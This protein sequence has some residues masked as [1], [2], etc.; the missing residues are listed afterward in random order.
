MSYLPLQGDVY[1]WT[2]DACTDCLV[3]LAN[4]D[5]PDDSHCR[6]LA[7]VASVRDYSPG[8]HE[9]GRECDSHGFSWSPCDLCGCHLGGDRYPVTYLPPVN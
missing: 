5:W 2:L 4:D 9:H 3:A 7:R 8:C 6:P 1:A